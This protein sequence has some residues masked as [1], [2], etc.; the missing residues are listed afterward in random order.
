[1]FED[2]AGAAGVW[3]GEFCEGGFEGED[4]E[5]GVLAVALDAVEEGGDIE[6]AGAGVDELEVDERG[7]HGAE[8]GQKLPGENVTAGGADWATGRFGAPRGRLPISMSSLTLT[9][10]KPLARRPSRVPGMASMLETWMSW[11]RMIAPGR[12]W[13]RMRLRVRAALLVRQSSGSTLHWMVG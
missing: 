11:T 5:V 1:M 10:R 8:R 3:R 7:W 12:V 4:A 13:L 9:K 2:A 6:D